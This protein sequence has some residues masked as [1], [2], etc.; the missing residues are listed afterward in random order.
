MKVGI[1]I[2]TLV[3]SDKLRDCL[4]SIE[5]FAK[6]AC[7]VVYNNWNHSGVGKVLQS[8]E[9]VAK[10]T[11]P[12]EDRTGVWVYHRPENV[13]VAGAWNRGLKRLF[14]W[15][16]DWA[17]VMNDDAELTE[18]TVEDL[19]RAIQG[20]FGLAW[21]SEA[22]A[23][24]A[25]HRR[26][27]DAIGW[28]DENLWPAYHEDEDFLHR[29]RLGGVTYGRAQGA[30]VRHAR[31]STLEYSDIL[32]FQHQLKLDQKSLIYY[33]RKWGG[34][35]NYEKFTS[36][37][38]DGR[39]DLAFWPDVVDGR[40]TGLKLNDRDEVI[41]DS[42][43]PFT[44][45]VYGPMLGNSSIPRVARGI[46]SGLQELGLLAGEVDMDSFDSA[47]IHEAPGRGASIGIYTGNPTHVAVTMSGGH[48]VVFSVLAPNSSWVPER[49]LKNLR[50]RSTVISPSSWGAEVLEKHGCQK[51]PALRH[52][53]SSSFKP[54]PAALERLQASYA[55][56]KFT[57]LHLSSSDRERKGTKELFEA[58][59]KLVQ[60]GALGKEPTLVALVDAP[61]GT[62]PEA[63]S[64]PSIRVSN[65]RIDASEEQMSLIY[66][67]FHVLCQ[68]SR[69]EGFGMCPL[70]ARASG[71]PVVAT[72]CTGHSEHMLPEPPGCVTVATGGYVPINDG[73]G[74][75][76]PELDARDIEYAL[77][78]AFSHW[79]RLVREARESAEQTRT[80]WSW[81]NQT[82]K[83]LEA[84]GLWRMT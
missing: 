41:I 30:E 1:V 82:R 9:T 5:R 32:R 42:D 39:N 23:C 6:D 44:A 75:T 28:F 66:Q 16:C 45:R 31:S 15:G 67:S 11:Q 65:Q 56:G 49:M 60:R 22:F 50:D 40:R 71:V 43:K 14:D 53:V 51:F 77:E 7:V 68:P 81:A 34:P 69:G 55:E 59:R 33:G 26:V 61:A 27:I 19:E 46:A 24:F 78:R 72:A 17:I 54:D 73:P 63:E 29:M 12:F 76:A 3:R 25:I 2:P 13:G 74:A 38:N 35:P 58:W 57:V 47:D 64:D 62:F 36:P 84:M 10:L 37:F 4:R 79:P 52:G 48:D 21:S 70:E 80:E 8:Y 20:G 83:W 18:R